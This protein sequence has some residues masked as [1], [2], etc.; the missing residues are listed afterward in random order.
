MLAGAAAHPRHREQHRAD[1][2]PGPRRAA[3]DA[4]GHLGGRAGTFRQSTEAAKPQR[5]IYAALGLDLPKKIIAIDPAPP[6]LP[7]P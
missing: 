5:D 7:A 4:R 3:A 1:L 2:E 6:E